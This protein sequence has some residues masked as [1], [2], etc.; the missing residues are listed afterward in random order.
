[1]AEPGTPTVTWTDR[2]AQLKDSAQERVL[3][4]P[5][6]TE[7]MEQLLTDGKAFVLGRFEDSPARYLDH[8][9]RPSEEGWIALDEEASVKLDLH[10]ERYR[11]A[12]GVTKVVGVIPATLSTDR[13]LSTPQPEAGTA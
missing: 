2:L 7:A 8:W 6:P 9:W 3:S 1:M 11:A 12:T 4:A 10:A 5:M 13:T